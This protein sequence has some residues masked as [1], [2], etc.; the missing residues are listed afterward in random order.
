MKTE[1]NDSP[2]AV[3]R[4]RKGTIINETL[5]ILR[6]L[7]DSY[8]DC[9]G[10]NGLLLYLKITAFC[11]ANDYRLLSTVAKNLEYVCKAQNLYVKCIVYE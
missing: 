6:Y 7:N 11:G 5:L 8:N 9:A 4:V 1:I 3:S 2:I 10:I